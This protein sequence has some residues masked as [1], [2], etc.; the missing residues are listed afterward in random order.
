MEEY[1][2]YA[3]T[4]PR[5]RCTHVHTSAKDNLRPLLLT[6]PFAEG[7][8]PGPFATLSTT[9]PLS[10][11]WLLVFLSSKAESKWNNCAFKTLP[12]SDKAQ[13]FH[14]AWPNHIWQTVFPSPL[15]TGKQQKMGYSNPV[16]NLWWILCP[17]KILALIVPRILSYK[18]TN[19]NSPVLLVKQQ[20]KI[21][22]IT[23]DMI[24]NFILY[25]ANMI[26]CTECCILYCAWICPDSIYEVCHLQNRAKGCIIC[27]SVNDCLVFLDFFCVLK[28]PFLCVLNITIQI[29]RWRQNELEVGG[30]LPIHPVWRK[31]VIILDRFLVEIYFELTSWT[32]QDIL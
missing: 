7:S 25:G 3:G 26:D 27:S 29:V 31:R 12:L 19:K 6:P 18:R 8:N 22:S 20:N 17:V 23:Y 2:C 5:R 1:R 11:M 16:E 14:T 10:H 24:L 9:Q 30:K 28:G 13:P 32:S 21:I 4:T 15:Y